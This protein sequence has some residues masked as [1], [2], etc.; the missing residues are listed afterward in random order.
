MRFAKT[1]GHLVVASDEEV[2]GWSPD[3]VADT[4]DTA[5]F[6]WCD[7]F[8][9][10]DESHRAALLRK[11]PDVADRIRVTGSARG[12]LLRSAIYERPHERAYVL[13]N[14]SFGLINSLWG[15]RESA[16]SIYAAGMR[17]DM[18]NPEHAAIMK[19]RLLYEETGLRETTKLLSGLLGQNKY[20]IIVR[21]HPS[22][23]TEFWEQL[24]RGHPHAHVIAK[25]DPYQWTKHAALMI[26]SDSTL[27]V[28]VTSLG[29]PA[30][31]LSTVDAWARRL[32]VREINFTVGSAAEAVDPIFRLLKYKEGPLAQPYKAEVFA[33]DSARRTAAEFAELLPDPAPIGPMGWE[34]F[35]RAPK[36]AEKFTVSAAEFRAALDRILPMAQGGGAAAVDLDDS[37]VLLVPP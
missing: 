20:D 6:K 27:G 11:F 8:F 4:T 31:N 14:T 32:V 33:P 24:V 22:E 28:E 34:R 16:I 3:L 2:L 37:V 17:W 19:S 21:P 9:A 30:L 26:H 18:G 35:P 15:S 7:R 23:K 10:F 5:T 36:E 29:T 12:D 1:N 25:S 13:F